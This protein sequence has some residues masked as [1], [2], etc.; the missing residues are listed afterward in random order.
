MVAN[1]HPFRYLTTYTNSRLME[2]RL[3][4]QVEREAIRIGHDVWIGRQAVVLKG[5][6]VGDGAVIGAGSVV[7]RD[8]PPFAV[9]AGTPAR[10]LKYR[11]SSFLIDQVQRSCWWDLSPEEL[12][13]F[14][15][16]FQIPI[17]SMTET[18][19]AVFE[20][21]GRASRASADIR[22]E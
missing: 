3:S 12:R 6:T 2:G 13:A 5:V 4:G 9:V 17:A 16:A 11:F 10:I 22:S 15:P 18:D 14:E 19:L 21:I 8:V 1:D 7:T 20:A